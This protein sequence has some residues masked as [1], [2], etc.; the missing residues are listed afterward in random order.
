LKIEPGTNEAL[1][2]V[3]AYGGNRSKYIL[4]DIDWPVSQKS[5]DRGSLLCKKEAVGVQSL[6]Y[7]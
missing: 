3:S 5:G 6:C 2:K 7:L 1:L 4:W